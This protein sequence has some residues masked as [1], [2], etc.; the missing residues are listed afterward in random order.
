MKKY[1]IGIV[2]GGGGALIGAGL[3][4]MILGRLWG[5]VLL[6]AGLGVWAFG[7]ARL[8]GASG[9]NSDQGTPNGLGTQQSEDVKDSPVV[10][11][12]QNATVW[13]QME[14]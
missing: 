10:Q 13:R 7:Y 2:F 14:K 5:V 3:V 6:L 12:E 11:R 1:E 9:N 4:W 8:M